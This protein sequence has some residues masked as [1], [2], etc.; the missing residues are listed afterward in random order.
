[1]AEE[2]KI[3]LRLG[4]IVRE[5]Y[6]RRRRATG[7][8]RTIRRIVARI[9]KI[10][11]EKVKIDPLLNEIIWSRGNNPPRRLRISVEYDEEEGL[12][13]VKPLFE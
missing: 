5:K 2:R 12:A 1:M 3:S 4:R 9:M 7:E 10:D 11:Q 13:T 6:P 8:V